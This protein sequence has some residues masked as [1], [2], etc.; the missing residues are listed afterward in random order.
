VPACAGCHSPTGSGIP[1]QFPRIG[2]QHA[3]YTTAQL[4]SFRTGAR[5]NNPTMVAVA[6]KLNDK[7]IQAVSDYV[8]GLR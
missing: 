1:G 6:A 7:E 4:T 2:G 3:D 8:A 5:A